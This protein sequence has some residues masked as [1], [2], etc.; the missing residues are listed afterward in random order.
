MG[1][2]MHAPMNSTRILLCLLLLTGSTVAIGAPGDSGGD[3]IHPEG[4]THVVVLGK[5]SADAFLAD[6]IYEEGDPRR[7]RT[8]RPV[9]LVPCHG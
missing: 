9:D 3:P 5:D 7:R 4:K 1:A 8:Q 2:T 6:A